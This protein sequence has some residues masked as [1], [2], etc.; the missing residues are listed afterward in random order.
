MR[1]SRNVKNGGTE[2]VTKGQRYCHPASLAA[3]ALVV[4]AR[5]VRVT[6][7]VCYPTPVRPPNQEPP[8]TLQRLCLDIY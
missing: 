7:G 6:R 5:G 8:L 2:L 1:I 4:S 3:V